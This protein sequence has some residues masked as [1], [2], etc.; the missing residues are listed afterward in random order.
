MAG[1]RTPRIEGEMKRCL[2][3]LMQNGVK[4]PGL[5]PLAG[6]TRV[7]V[8]RDL[9]YAKVY[10]SVYDT[11]EMKASTME[12]LKRAEPFLRSRL[13]QLIRIRRIPNMTFVLDNSI[14]Y[15]LHISK[16][17]QDISDKDSARPQREDD[18]QD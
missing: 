1:N 9:S 4:D 12:A 7:E 17:L 13:N 15:S 16:L 2:A 14:E 6:V 11:D 8:S 3:E 5:S 18:E 10:V